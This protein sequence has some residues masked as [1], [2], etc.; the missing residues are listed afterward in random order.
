MAIADGRS[1]ADGRRSLGEP[2]AGDRD[3]LLR[4]FG[5]SVR[6]VQGAVEPGLERHIQDG[7]GR[8]N[9]TVIISTIVMGAVALVVAAVMMFVQKKTQAGIDRAGQPAQGA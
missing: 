8:M 1:G 2:D 9:P 7:G 6:R 4:V 5:F 3:C